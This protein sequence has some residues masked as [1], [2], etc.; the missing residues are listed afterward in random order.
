VHALHQ[1]TGPVVYP[2]PTPVPSR[3]R[4]PGSVQG[5]LS[6]NVQSQVPNTALIGHHEYARPLAS[7]HVLPG[8]SSGSDPSYGMHPAPHQAMHPPPAPLTYNNSGS[9]WGQPPAQAGYFPSES[10]C[11]L[12]QCGINIAHPHVNAVLY[13]DPIPTG[14]QF[15]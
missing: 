10:S 3:Y 12:D 1:I 5:Q 6:Y 15:R 14:Q 13:Y 4:P 9:S 2:I 11:F 7:Y 8:T